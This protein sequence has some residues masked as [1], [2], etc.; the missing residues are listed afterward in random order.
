MALPNINNNDFSGWVKIVTNSFKQADLTSYIETF[1]EQ[2]LRSIIGNAAFYKIENETRTKWTDL[3]DG[4]NY[5]NFNSIQ[6][7]FYGLKQPLIYF[8]YFEY[9]RDNFISTQ[10]GK[11]KSSS[12]NSTNLNPEATLNLARSRYNKAVQLIN[13]SLPNFLETYKEIKTHITNSVDN[14]DNTYTLT[15]SNTKYLEA[16]DTL[17]ISNVSYDVQSI[18]EDASIVIDAGQTGLDFNGSD[19]IWEPFEDVDFCILEYCGI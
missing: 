2:Y 6:D 13:N 5:K 1:R 8:I 9:V 16:N 19:A 4:V 15:V 3:L 17:K 11:V 7:Y 12:E 14:L 18:V 10:T